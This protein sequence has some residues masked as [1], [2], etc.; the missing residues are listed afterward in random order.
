MEMIVSKE[1]MNYLAQQSSDKISIILSGM[2][3]L[4]ENTD[5]KVAIM[6]SQTW[7]Q[8]MAQTI[9]GKNKITKEEIQRNHDKLNAYMAE[10]MAELYNR[11]C[12]NDE[13]MMS[14]GTQINELYAEHLQLKEMLGA[15]VIKLNE[16]IES[17]DNFHML[18][19]EIEQG[20]YS[21]YD[22]LVSICIVMSQMDRRILEDDRKLAI[23]K[24]SLQNQGIL[25]QVNIDIT[26]FLLSVI[27]MPVDKVGLIYMELNC[28][29]QNFVA[30]L[31][32]DTIENYHFLPDMAKR[33]KNKN[34]IVQS[35]I[36][37]NQL[38][39]DIT[40]NIA[41]VYD[42]F[43]Q[44]KCSVS[45][46]SE[47]AIT[48]EDSK[49]SITSNRIYPDDSNVIDIAEDGGDKVFEDYWRLRESGYTLF[50]FEKYKG[51][52][53]ELNDF[54]N[55]GDSAA[56]YYLGISYYEDKPDFGEYTYSYVNEEQNEQQPYSFID[57]IDRDEQLALEYF[58]KAALQGDLSARIKMAEISSIKG[59]DNRCIQI[60]EE[61]IADKGEDSYYLYE[62]ARVLSGG[63]IADYIINCSF[64]VDNED[65]AKKVF[66]LLSKA[67]SMDN[68]EANYFMAQVY[69]IGIE[70][71]GYEVDYSEYKK[72]LEHAA[73]LE[74]EEALAEIGANYYHGTSG[75]PQNYNKAHQIFE[76][77]SLIF[78]EQAN[79]Y[80]GLLH[81]F[82]DGGVEVDD[83]KA[84]LCFEIA[85]KSWKYE[86]AYIFLAEAAYKGF[87]LF[88][89]DEN[90]NEKA[91]RY[92]QE[93]IYNGTDDDYINEAKEYRKEWFRY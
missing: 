92:L 72:Y 29:P 26:D 34:S 11:E 4:M 86:R 19:T 7:Y 36:S 43:M 88:A 15:F 12:I 80:H 21:S 39:E 17:I 54:A 31:V 49:I 57:F 47:T 68:P 9:T 82:G 38:Q 55:R 78:N 65:E 71:I 45:V 81:W 24:R 90:N 73:S 56:L 91:E 74:S 41:E 42:D 18:N 67:A 77:T 16:K 3:A 59:E 35:I 64:E 51:V 10:A 30:K 28:I 70:D 87:G 20:V 14:L 63:D 25:N 53:D 79:Y 58:E 23:L 61:I 69:D 48:T 27:N 8:R 60:M 1:D 50:E 37:N 76:D 85:A 93:L 33:M 2:T 89:F 32:L 84:C 62:F 13:I 66:D 40:L 44:S 5:Q 83:A 22:P 75:Y 46:N 6:E 52:W